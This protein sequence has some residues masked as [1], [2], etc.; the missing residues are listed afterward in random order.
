[1]D[2][3][4]VSTKA[5]NL[6]FI[7]HATPDDNDFTSW[8]SARLASAGYEVWSDLT[9]LVGGEVFW[10][11]IEEALR[12]HSI[13][14]LSVLSPVAVGKRGFQ[15]ELSVA[16]S[17]EAK[18]N[19]GD[20]IIPLRISQIPYDEIPIHIH[21][22]NVI[23]FTKGWHI[24]LARL[25]EKLEKDQV[26]RQENVELALS[27]WAKGFLEVDKLLDKNDEEVISN[28]LSILEM[29]STINI[30][31]F[32][33]TP[34]NIDPLKL[35][36]PCRQIENCVISFANA[37]DFNTLDAPSALKKHSEIEI[38]TFLQNGSRSVSQLSYQDRSNVLTDLLRQSWERY[39]HRQ[40][41]LGFALANN[42]LCWYL[43]KTKPK[44]D[45]T[46][47]IDAL[48]NSGSRAL[49]GKSEKLQA[50]WHLAIEAVPSVGKKN[51]FTLLPHVIFTSDG[52]TPI[53]DPAQ[54]HRLRRRFCKSWWQNRWRDLTSA[55]LA[56]IAKN[57][58]SIMM[59]VAPN[60][61]VEVNA[62]PL[63]YIVPVKTFEKISNSIAIDDIEDA[64]LLHDDK[65]DDS[66][67]YQLEEEEAQ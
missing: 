43:P 51:R 34:K 8:L 33:S 22:K 16:D 5:R 6:I 56:E 25:L 52:V 29:P 23:D 63:T 27:N 64:D 67:L 58:H 39:V 7:S 55:Y 20:F 21:N 1:M 36:W 10:N 41:M 62:F 59:P 2:K 54:M 15:K 47:F 44:I 45:R 18:G 3:V 66:Y 35:Q 53:G 12:H 49:L 9:Q 48:G 26:P 40:G 65:E 60:R 37:K 61:N 19:L 17:I 24:G 46:K 13:K 14:F 42:K 28:W 4:A 50:F 31:Y 38:T 32:D 11:D 57:E 30:S